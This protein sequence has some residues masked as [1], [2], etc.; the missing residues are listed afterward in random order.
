MEN[1]SKVKRQ[2]RRQR[3]KQ[4]KNKLGEKCASQDVKDDGRA[5]AK[6]LSALENNHQT[7]VSTRTTTI[8]SDKQ[9]NN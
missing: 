2:R 9:Q 4:A 8:T 3:S 1:S 7:A 5:G 6:A